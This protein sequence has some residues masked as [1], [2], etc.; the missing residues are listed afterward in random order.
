MGIDVKAVGKVSSDVARRR[1]GLILLMSCLTAPLGIIA[2][3]AW[4]YVAG[5]GTYGAL[6]AVVVVLWCFSLRESRGKFNRDD[7]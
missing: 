1:G 4:G 3:M 2:W 5:L 7:V 6:I